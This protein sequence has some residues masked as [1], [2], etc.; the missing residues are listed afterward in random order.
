M[1]LTNLQSFLIFLIFFGLGILLSCLFKALN[2]GL[3]KLA[4]IILAP[5]KNKK[6]NFKTPI[7]LFVASIVFAIFTLSFI[8][9]ALLTNHG[10]FRL[11]MVVACL[12]GFS[13]A[14]KLLNIKFKQKPQEKS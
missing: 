5:N 12:L 2:A 3:N 7:K 14:T 1:F 10:L 11:F 8:Y 6:Y 4:S 13:L 9:I